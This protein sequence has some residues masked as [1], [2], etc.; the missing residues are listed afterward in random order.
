MRL[1]TKHLEKRVIRNLGRIGIRLSKWGSWEGLEAASQIPR[2]RNIEN[3]RMEYKPSGSV[4]DVGC[5]SGIMLAT[6]HKSRFPYV[7]YCGIDRSKGA[8]KLARSRIEDRDLESFIRGDMRNAPLLNDEKFDFIIFNEVLYYL[9][10]PVALIEKYQ[11]LLKETGVFVVSIYK[12]PQT[13]PGNNWDDTWEKVRTAY[14]TQCIEYAFVGGEG[15]RVWRQGLYS[16]DE[17]TSCARQ[18]IVQSPERS[19]VT[20]YS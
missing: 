19:P 3:W 13:V 17:V 2:Y 18:Q 9:G 15:N 6:I 8:I 4:L 11:S 16:K 1:T 12:D 7:R 5:G 14:E 10:D 20:I